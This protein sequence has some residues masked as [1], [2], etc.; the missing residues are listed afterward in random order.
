MKI[1]TVIGARPQ[2][3]KAAMVSRSLKK[4]FIK[5]IILHTGQHY[6][7]E[8]SN[9]FLKLG[10]PAPDYNLD[11]NNLSHGAM[12]GLMIVEIEKVLTFE[13]P[14]YLLVYGD[15]NSTL[16]GAI[17][18]KKMNTKIIHIEAG[19]RSNNLLMP[20][21]INRIL[22]DR[23]SDILFC[24]SNDAK[25]N[26]IAE[27]QDRFNCRIEVCGDVMEDAV[28]FFMPYAEQKSKILNEYDLINNHYCIFTIHREENIENLDKFK[29]IIS[30]INDISEKYKIVIPLHP[31]QTR[32]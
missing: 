27:S 29:K 23:I 31:G 1:L 14:D 9:V 8:M 21:E 16:A 18:A 5:E 15:T 6:D 26:L 2:F 13:K 24:P 17:A 32:N 12:T 28:K 11:I 30:T 7:N 25:N 20:E 19:L 22:T 4:A 3:I 10:L